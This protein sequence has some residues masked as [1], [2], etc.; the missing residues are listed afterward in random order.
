MTDPERFDLSPLDPN[1]DPVR[2]EA[3]TRETLRRV[4]GVMR[5]RDASDEALVVIAGWMKPVLLAAGVLLAILIPT[6]IALEAR[7][8]RLERVA[9]LVALSSGSLRADAPPSGQDFVRALARRTP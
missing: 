4:D 8:N 3:H 2:W 1:E 5:Q 6:E 7:E 9:R